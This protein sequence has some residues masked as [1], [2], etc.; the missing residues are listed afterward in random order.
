M[1]TGFGYDRERRSRQGEIAARL[2]GRVADIRRLG[3]A[4]LDL[5]FVAAGQLDGFYEAGLN[6]WDYAAGALI[7][8]EAGCLTTGLRGRSPDSRFVAAAGSDFAP[9]L[10]AILEELNADDV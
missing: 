8:A 1:G 3:S 5:C 2:L 10:F 4:A 6:A 9:D 7:A